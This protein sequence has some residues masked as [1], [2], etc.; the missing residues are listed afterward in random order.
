MAESSAF[1]NGQSISSGGSAKREL[2]LRDPDQDEVDNLN[3]VVTRATTSY[4]VNIIWC[5]SDFNELETES[6]A[7]GVT[8]GTQTTA[9]QTV[10]SPYAKVEVADAGSGSGDADLAATFE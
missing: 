1:M 2:K 9:S 8:A 3:L 10:R 4:D 5:D 7:S 6:V